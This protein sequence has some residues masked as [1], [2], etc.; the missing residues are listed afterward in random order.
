MKK[1]LFPPTTLDGYKLGHPAQYPENTETVFSNG[2]PRKSRQEGVKQI[3]LA[4]LQAF[5]ADLVDFWNENFFSQPL[6]EV[7][8]RFK[9]RTDS[10]LGPDSVNADHIKA[11]HELGYLPLQIMALPEGS[12]VDMRVAPFVFF[13]T[14]KKFGWFTNS[15]ETIMS[16]SIW[17]PCT[18]ATTAHQY[19]KLL[20]KYAVKTVGNTA[21]VDWQG[22]DF[23]MRGI[24]GLDGALASGFGHLISFCGTDTVPA[25]DWVDHYYFADSTKKL[26]GGSIPATEH[27]V[28]CAGGLVNEMETFVRLLTKTYPFGP[29][30]IVSDTWD[31]WKVLTVTLPSIKDVI[32][33]RQPDKLGRPGKLVIRPDS[34]DPIRIVAGYKYFV[35]QAD[36]A[37][38][39]TA[40][41]LHDAGY[42]YLQTPEGQWF[43]ICPP[44]G[45]GASAF[46]IEASIKPHE[47]KGSIEVLWELFGGT[48]SEQ[49]YK[50]LDEHI[51]LI[52]GDSIT[53]ERATQIVERLVE[54]GFASTNVV[55]GIGS[56]TY[57][58]VT[59]DTHGWAVKATWAQVDGVA[60]ELFK[61]PATDDGTKK[62]AK[63]L[64]A[65]Y[66][67]QET[68]HYDMKDQVTW[69]EV[70]NCAYQT[71]LIDGVV[72]NQQ[73]L[74]EIREVLKNQYAAQVAAG[75]DT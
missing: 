52:Y 43:K 18:S 8:A 45:L 59:R 29:V 19:R 40:D 14:H 73:T 70:M 62:S 13:S 64:I 28:M 27:A 50:C 23:S 53:I 57:Q 37:H 21:F 39:M 74:Q 4:G 71:I 72:Q 32:M 49:G 48:V 44:P 11:L 15:I 54:K 31:Y 60:Y 42:E 17:G 22:H 47:I 6:D 3:V 10:Y 67:N 2:T 46:L 9:D 33:A 30:S 56:F 20:D 68:G 35:Q 41:Q 26:V 16:L 58:M 5:V 12:L 34:G 66:Y 38:G 65:V 51:G 1:Y 63:G 55:F 24:N 69:D 36:A 7:L 75:T 25:L 61:D